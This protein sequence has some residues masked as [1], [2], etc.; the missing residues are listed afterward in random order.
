MPNSPAQEE[1]RKEWRKYCRAFE[2]I[3]YDQLADWWLGKIAQMKP[4]PPSPQEVEGW[5]EEFDGKIAESFANGGFMTTDFHD[6][7]EVDIGEV[8]KFI[9]SLLASHDTA[10]IEILER[11]IKPIKEYGNRKCYSIA[12]INETYNAALTAA[13]ALVG[14]SQ[15]K[16]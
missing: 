10:L 8:K 9:R 7:W 5:E 4:A 3:S 15:K 12:D 13:I 2:E 11:G 14:S 1:M 6:G 16:I